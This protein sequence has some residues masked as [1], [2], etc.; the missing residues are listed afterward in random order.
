MHAI[1]KVTVTLQYSRQWRECI[2]VILLY[3]LTNIT[4][5][6]QV[7]GQF[8]GGGGMEWWRHAP[9]ESFVHPIV[10]MGHCNIQ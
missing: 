2:R 8:G 7:V 4:D 3:L 6:E 9:Q 10:F 1:A 5:P